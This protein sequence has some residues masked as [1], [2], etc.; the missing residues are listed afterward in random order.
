[1]MK[2]IKNL[3]G[4]LF[5]YLYSQLNLNTGSTK[6][7]PGTTEVT[8]LLDD[9]ETF[10]ASLDQPN[11]NDLCPVTSA[12]ND[13]I[14]LFVDRFAC[15][16]GLNPGIFQ[17]VRE[18]SIEECILLNALVACETPVS[19]GEILLLESLWVKRKWLFLGKILCF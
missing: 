7:I 13:D 5:Q 6:H 1:M 9:P 2:T 12:N 17:I 14:R 15:E 18:L 11:S 10:H 16:A 19:F 4:Y 3:P 8:S